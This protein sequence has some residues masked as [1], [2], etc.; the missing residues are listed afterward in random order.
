[1]I[2]QPLRFERGVDPVDRHLEGQD[3]DNAV[4]GAGTALYAP[5]LRAPLHYG[6]GDE[7]GGGTVGRRVRFKID[8]LYEVPVV[9]FA[10]RDK[11]L[12]EVRILVW[13]V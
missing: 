11:R 12:G 3:T 1:M 9:G 7:G 13:A 4:F 6:R 5:P 10:R 2:L 8:N